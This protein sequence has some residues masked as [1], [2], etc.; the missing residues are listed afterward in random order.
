M[1]VTVSYRMFVV[2]AKNKKHAI[3]GRNMSAYCNAETAGIR[4]SGNAPANGLAFSCREHAAQNDPKKARISRAKRSA[5]MPGWTAGALPLS[6]SAMH[7][8]NYGLI[9][10]L[11]ASVFLAQI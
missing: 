5:A 4:G 3:V 11:F 6:T 7:P 8:T 2:L 9:A 10:N 1:I